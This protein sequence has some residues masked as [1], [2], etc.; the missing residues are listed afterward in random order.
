MFFPYDTW[1]N[2]RA[3]SLSCICVIKPRIWIQVPLA[4]TLNSSHRTFPLLFK[5]KEK[6]VV[7][8]NS[9]KNYPGEENWVEKCSCLCI[10]NLPTSSKYIYITKDS[11][12]LFREKFVVILR[13]SIPGGTTMQTKICFRVWYF[14]SLVRCL[15]TQHPM[16]LHFQRKGLLPKVTWKVILLKTQI[17][18]HRKTTAF[19]ESCDISVSIAMLSNTI[20]FKARSCSYILKNII[21][22]SG[23]ETK[24]IY[25]YI[26]IQYRQ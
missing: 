16:A 25:I 26:Y 24:Y 17:I 6:N 11:I 23:L 20:V 3:K 5:G 19:P 7:L 22:T 18:S 1:R 2:W 12:S 21:T 15:S 14:F 8:I 10:Y 13:E 4:H 9:R